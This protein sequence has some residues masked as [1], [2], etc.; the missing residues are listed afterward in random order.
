MTR[1]TKTSSG[2]YMVSGK[3][4]DMLVGTRAQVWHGTAYKTSGGLCKPS[5]MMN[6]AGRLVS[7]SKHN[8]AKREKRLVKAGF[9]TQKGKF[10][11]V[12]LNGTSKRGRKGKRGKKSKMRGGDG[13]NY[14][15]S[16][17]PYDGQGVGTSGNA[18]QFAAGRGN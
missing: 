2:K 7:K 15:L 3:S 13:T 11:Y 1:F 16:P 4:Y 10:G 5:I 8:S 6:K 18:V 14:A 9:G 17:T 12:K